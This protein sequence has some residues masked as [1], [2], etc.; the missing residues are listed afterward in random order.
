MAEASVL[1]ADLRQVDGPLMPTY[2][3]HRHTVV[4]TAVVTAANETEA[5][6][7]ARD[8]WQQDAAIASLSA[9]VHRQPH[10]DFTRDAQSELRYEE[11]EADRETERLKGLRMG[12]FGA[13]SDGEELELW[14]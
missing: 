10:V 14:P 9:T 3:V 5:R 12:L 7:I 6:C 4:T 1:V 11:T 13:E 8:I 2:E